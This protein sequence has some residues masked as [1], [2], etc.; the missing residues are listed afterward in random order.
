[1]LRIILQSSQ[2]ESL[3]RRKGAGDELTELLRA[4]AACWAW[5]SGVLVLR[6]FTLQCVSTTYLVFPPCNH[7]DV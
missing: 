2:H 1:M 7:M 6:A 4:G 3:P 5:G